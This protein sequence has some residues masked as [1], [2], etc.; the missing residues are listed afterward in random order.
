MCVCAYIFVCV[1]IYMCIYVC[2]SIYIYHSLGI[3]LDRLEHNTIFIHCLS[4][5]KFHLHEA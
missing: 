5:L 2:V 1:C 3:R 4:L